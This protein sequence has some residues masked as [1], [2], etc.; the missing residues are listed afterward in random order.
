MSNF[1]EICSF[2]FTYCLCKYLIDEALNTGN[3]ANEE[4]VTC[5]DDVVDQYRNQIVWVGTQIN[6]L[7]NKNIYFDTFWKITLEI[8]PVLYRR[9]RTICYKQYSIRIRRSSGEGS[10]SSVQ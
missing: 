10:Q 4:S 3:N 1:P 2:P 5:K 9:K 6:V 7:Y 8:L